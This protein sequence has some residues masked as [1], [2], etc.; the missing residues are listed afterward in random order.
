[1]A[2][3]AESCQQFRVIGFIPFDVMYFYGQARAALDAAVLVSFQDEGF[4][5]FKWGFELSAFYHLVHSPSERAIGFGLFS[6]SEGLIHY[7]RYANPMAVLGNVV[8]KTPF[9]DDITVK[10]GREDTPG[11][12]LAYNRSR[13][14]LLYFLVL[15]WQM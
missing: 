14:Y 7:R 6:C 1:V 10:R 4:Y 9:A 5:S 2:K 8:E 3:V 11:L 12:S 15:R 13:R